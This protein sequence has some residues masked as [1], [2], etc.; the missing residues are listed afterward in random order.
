MF[1]IGLLINIRKLCCLFINKK[2]SVTFNLE[3]C[4][5][6]YLFI[7][8]YFFNSISI[9]GL[10]KVNTLTICDSYPIKDPRLFSESFV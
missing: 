8:I 9:A 5:F 7:V 6:T 4:L 10:L 2:I 1:I 3:T